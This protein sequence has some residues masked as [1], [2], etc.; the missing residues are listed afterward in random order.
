[1]KSLITLAGLGFDNL[2]V[3]QSAS[4]IAARPAEAPFGYVV[5]PNADHL[6]RVNR[7]SELRAIYRGAALCLL[8]SRVVGWLARLMGLPAPAIAPGSDLTAH[9]LAHHLV[10]GERI[11]IVGLAPVWLPALIARCGLAPPAHYNPPMGFDRD[12]VAFANTIAFVRANPARLVFLAVGSPRQEVL[13][14]ALV[15]AGDITGTGLCIG[16]S[17]EFLSGASRRAPRILQRCGLEWL[18]RFAS[19]PRKLFRRY[20]INSPKVIALLAKQ[21]FLQH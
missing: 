4:W 9:L 11:T 5:T 13:A 14:A 18:F 3:M 19:N 12:P 8:D 16:A 2:D 17:L 1:M 21:R 20:V 7:D 15:A 6:V 10:P